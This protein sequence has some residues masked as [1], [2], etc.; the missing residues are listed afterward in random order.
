VVTRRFATLIGSVDVRSSA[1][2]AR[3]QTTLEFRDGS[4]FSC[5][6]GDALPAGYFVS[7]TLTSGTRVEL[8]VERGAEWVPFRSATGVTS[9]SCVQPAIEGDVA[10]TLRKPSGWL[11]WIHL[12]ALLVAAWMWLHLQYFGPAWASLDEL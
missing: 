9:D 10:P 5:A 4:S 2:V 7:D 11:P 3:Q 6:E 12:A 1:L 8:W